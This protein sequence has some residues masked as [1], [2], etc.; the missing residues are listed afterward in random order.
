M[1]RKK[2]W[3]SDVAL[4]RFLLSGDLYKLV[5]CIVS[6]ETSERERAFFLLIVFFARSYFWDCF[7]GNRFR[8]TLLLKHI[9]CN[10]GTFFRQ[11]L[12]ARSTFEWKATLRKLFC[13]SIDEFIMKENFYPLKS[14]FRELFARFFVAP[15]LY[16]R[17]L[18]KKKTFLLSF[19]Q[20]ETFPN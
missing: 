4:F 5:L 17:T 2:K 6:I 18:P 7:W 9:N 11:F 1:L 10:W 3:L 16:L 20:L 19:Q 8:F 12:A 13:V 15:C 14:F